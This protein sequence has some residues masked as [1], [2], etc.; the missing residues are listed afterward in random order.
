MS[1][2]LFRTWGA[3]LPQPLFARALAAAG[4]LGPRVEALAEATIIDAV[5]ALRRDG[6][7]I[8]VLRLAHLAELV[9]AIEAGAADLPSAQN[10]LVAWERFRVAWFDQPSPGVLRVELDPA[11]AGGLR[12]SIPDVHWLLRLLFGSD[13]D[14]ADSA[15]VRVDEPDRPVAWEWPLRVG[16]LGDPRSRALAEQ[17]CAVRWPDLLRLV[18][19][20][21]ADEDC[22]LLLLPD[23]LRA[24]LG[25]VLSRPRR[26]RADCVLL[27]GG[28]GVANERVAR[29]V[30][31]LRQEVFTAGVGVMRIDSERQGEWFNALLEQLAHDLPIDVALRRA[32]PAGQ[33]V[34]VP[35]LLVASRRLA[36]HAR[37]TAFARRLGQHARRVVAEQRQVPPQPQQRVERSADRSLPPMPAPVSR[38]AGRPLTR[39]APSPAS[40][41][42]PGPA[43]G[44][45]S[46]SGSGLSSGRTP[47]SA[48]ALD[49]VVAELEARASRGV[50]QSESDDATAVAALRSALETELGA[51]LA[52]PRVGAGGVETKSSERRRVNFTVTDLSD[53]A[54]PVRVRDRLAADRAY[55]IALDIGLPRA[56]AEAASEVFASER[57]PP[58]AAGH[59]LDVFFVPLVRA[60]DGRLHTPQQARLFLPPEADSDAGY[61]S[62]RT[63][64]VRQQYRARVLITH[65]NRVIQTL[66]FSSPLGD[67]GE[68]FALT[69]ENIVA[70]T[71]DPAWHGQPFDAAI[72]V[73]HSGEGQPGFTTI[74]G[75]EVSFR[76]PV[77]IDTLVGEVKRL[78]SEEASFPEARGTLDDPALLKLFDDLAH[79]G[80]SILKPL[81]PE[82]QGRVA[83][84]ARIQIV[85]ARSGAWLPVEILYDSPLPKAGAQLCP[86]ARAALLREGGVSHSTCDHRDDRN[87]HCPLRFWG[88]SSVIERQPS[89]TP[90]SGADYVISVPH[91]DANR[92]DAFRSV[93]VGASSRVRAQDLG[94][95]GGVVEAVRRVAQNARTVKDWNE[96]EDAV[97]EESPSLLLLLPHSMEDQAHPGIAGLEIGGVLLTYPELE[98]TYVAGPAASSPVVLLLG[99]S[100][101]LT[102]VPFL[103]FVEAFKRERAALVIGTLATM[104]G[105]RA[106]AFVSEL[107]DGLKA[108]AGSERTFGE[109]FLDSKRRLLANGD[110]FV[111]SLTAYGD[112]GWRI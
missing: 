21:A 5:R 94:D 102:D 103:N 82:L 58:S 46:G 32:A 4:M 52:A 27:I 95:P 84:G 57:L 3:E 54:R 72:V 29:L 77:G 6:G 9:A 30:A 90:P 55:Q 74:V 108:A 37:V 96:W 53:A 51:A 7:D 56:Q 71:F 11:V 66:I 100:T 105:R 106:V 26:L 62:F 68:R 2:S 41:P 13:D 34:P 45:I 19:V 67:A 60:A 36:V 28:A 80:R 78:L 73:N 48:A 1:R 69:V 10:F 14:L 50:W 92:L 91:A 112:V 16:L 24:G 81:P 40:G 109:V 33:E 44:P 98:S 31:A 61:F 79:Y 15:Y 65:E 12:H 93:L 107:L 49:G 63:H 39:S 59:W 83:E 70:P 75:K 85:E 8:A 42:A 18:D 35:P 23:D 43:P 86:N 104:R 111:L 99:C 17:L 22:D 110:G 76:E 88:F 97:E 25:R 101:Q 64:G 20:D 89:L 38:S 87:F 47:D